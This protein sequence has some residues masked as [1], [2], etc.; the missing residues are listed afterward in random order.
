MYNDHSNF[1][2]CDFPLFLVVAVKVDHRGPIIRKHQSP[3]LL[4]LRHHNSQIFCSSGEVQAAGGISQTDD[5]SLKYIVWSE[6]IDHDDLINQLF[7]DMLLPNSPFNIL[8]KRDVVDLYDADERLIF[9]YFADLAIDDISNPDIEA[10]D[11]K[12]IF[13]KVSIIPAA[14]HTNDRGKD[15]VLVEIETLLE[16]LLVVF[17][18]LLAHLDSLVQI[19]VHQLI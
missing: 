4:S 12:F 10:L 15:K 18:Q 9:P 6:A 8:A 11:W 13:N 1:R 5:F 14:Q 16:L 19:I 2:L 3:R 17:G 7:P